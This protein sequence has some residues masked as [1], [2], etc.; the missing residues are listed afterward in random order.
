MSDSVGRQG[1]TGVINSDGKLQPIK[2]VL[3]YRVPI[4]GNAATLA[5]CNWYVLKDYGVALKWFF[6][7]CCDHCNAAQDEVAQL[8]RLG[9][10]VS[11]LF[12]GCDLHAVQL[13][14]VNSVEAGWGKQEVSSQ[15]G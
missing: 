14:L 6:W 9:N 13:P 3:C 5:E 15:H 4:D 1:N 10:N 2:R 11:L 12:K 7:W 8:A